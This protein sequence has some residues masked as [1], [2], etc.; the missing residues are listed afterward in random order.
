[1]ADGAGSTPCSLT[2]PENKKKNQINSGLGG[3]RLL[4]KGTTS[5]RVV[6]TPF[7]TPYVVPA[8]A[9]TCHKVE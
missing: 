6:F 2:V 1:M 5:P 9:G 3:M 4:Q 8:E 7:T